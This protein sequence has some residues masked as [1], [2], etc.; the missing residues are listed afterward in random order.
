MA[1]QPL[2]IV[3]GYVDTDHGQIHY[4]RCGLGVPSVLM[5]HASPG[6]SIMFVSA[7]KRLAARGLHAVAVDLPNC[8]ESCRTAEEPKVADLADAVLQAAQALRFSASIDLI[9][10]HTGAIVA[11]YIASELP[12]AVRRLVLWG[13]PVLGFMERGDVMREEPPD[14]ENDLVGVIQEYTE[15]RYPTPVPWQ[16]KVR[17]LIDM[18]QMYERR[19]WTARAAAA[20]DPG[21]ILKT[22][23]TPVLFMAGDGEQYQKQTMK[24]ALLCQNGKYVNLGPA[25]S[26]VVDEIPDEYVREV[27]E[28]LSGAGAATERASMTSAAQHAAPDEPSRNLSEGRRNS[29]HAPTISAA[30]V[31]APVEKAMLSPASPADKGISPKTGRASKDLHDAGSSSRRSSGEKKKILS[32]FKK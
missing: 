31:A 18:L 3:K 2:Y 13:V 17:S 4:R 28:F 12:G 14:Y 22:I 29:A 9:G 20:V 21:A 1:A 16:L 6:S 24:A 23:E 19:T 5:L 25:G 8:G 27:Y 15:K 11:A 7:L 10:H 30:M 32:L 26:D